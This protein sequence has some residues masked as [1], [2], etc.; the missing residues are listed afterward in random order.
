MNK[1]VMLAAGVVAFSSVASA[2]EYSSTAYAPAVIVEAYRAAPGEF[3]NLSPAQ[4][5]FFDRYYPIDWMNAFKGNLWAKFGSAGVVNKFLIDSGFPDLAKCDRI[6]A[7]G[8]LKVK[9]EHKTSGKEVPMTVD[10]RAYMGAKFTRSKD[11][12][13]FGDKGSPILQIDSKEGGWKVLL[14]RADA[15][16]QGNAEVL[17]DIGKSMLE[18]TRKGQPLM[19][20]SHF[21]VPASKAEAMVDVGKFIGVVKGPLGTDSALKQIRFEF[22]HLGASGEAAFMATNRSAARPAE[23]VYTFD[24]PYYMV[25]VKDGFEEPAFTAYVG[26]D[27]WKVGATN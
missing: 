8:V 25:F 23:T 20:Y 5:A 14:K 15:R 19:D 13:A 9:V 4:K 12:M 17:P 22:D 11:T 3:S 10:G 6:C 26:R 21:L 24:G 18:L 2:A 27:A 1:I 7:A 16:F